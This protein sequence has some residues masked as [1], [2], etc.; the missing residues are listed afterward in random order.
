M[1]RISILGSTGSIGT[2]ALDVISRYPDEFKIIGLSAGSNKEK[3]LEQAMKFHPK[4]L[5]ISRKEDADYL[6]KNLQIK[7]NIMYGEEGNEAVATHE[8]IDIVIVAIAGPEAILPTYKA[9]NKKKDIAL[10]AKEILV[11]CGEFI[12]KAAKYNKVRIIP[13]DSEHS[14][15]FQCLRGENIKEVEKI[16]LTASGGPFLYYEKERF[17]QI[18]LQ[19]ALKHPCW[20]MGKKITID[21][22]TLM[23]KGLELIEAYYFFNINSNK[24]DV[25]IH[26]QSIIHS[27]V[28]FRDGAI[29]AQMSIPDMRIP[30]LYAL[31]YPRR[32]PLDLPALDLPK[33]NNLTFIK[34]DEEKFPC[35]KLAK[36]ALR[37]GN[38]MTTILNAANDI[39]VKAFLKEKVS[40]ISIS[41]II[42]KALEHFDNHKVKSIDEALQLD[43]E[44]REYTENV[45]IPLFTRNYLT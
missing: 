20:K 40:F 38:S 13:V 7:A 44:V 2:N 9:I 43:K 28:V 14:A 33:I 8:E 18:T 10:A 11:S 22:A 31:S 29:K 30:I 21:S 37:Q 17:N 35:L 5:S 27:L 36:E 32:L 24:L 42:E 3:L 23:N 34:P 1:K 45:F 25:L 41:K 19:E 12:I 16:I 4:I 39:A 26:P 6:E 15:I